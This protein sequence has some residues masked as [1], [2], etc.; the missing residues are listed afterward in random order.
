MYVYAKGFHFVLFYDF[1]IEFWNCDDSM[2][3]FVF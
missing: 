2:V 1:P 3:L